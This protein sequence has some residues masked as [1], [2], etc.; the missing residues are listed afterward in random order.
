MAALRRAVRRPARVL[1]ALVLFAGGGGASLG[2]ERCGGVRVTAAV[3]L[4][5]TAAA[6]HAANLP[7]HTVLRVDLSDI[8]SAVKALVR[9]GPWDVC[10]LSAP[11]TDFSAAGRRVEGA[12]AELTLHGLE[13]AERLGIPTL[14]FENV[15]EVRGSATWEKA[16]VLMRRGG[17]HVQEAV[18]DAQ[19]FGVPQRRERHFAL[20]V[21]MAEP[22]TLA[23]F[24]EQLDAW[25]AESCKVSMADVL[26][27]VGDFVFIPTRANKGCGAAVR[28]TRAVEGAHGAQWSGVAPTLTTACT[29][30]PRAEAYTPRAQDAA[31]LERATRLS[32]AQVG[33][34][35]GFPAT[36][37]WPSRTKAGVM[38]GNAVAPPVMTAVMEAA[39]ATGQVRARE[40]V[41]A[42]DAWEACAEWATARAAAPAGVGGDVQEFEAD[43]WE[44]AAE[45]LRTELAE[46]RGRRRRPKSSNPE[47]DWALAVPR[48]AQDPAMARWRAGCEKRGVETL[49]AAEE[50]EVGLGRRDARIEDEPPLL[51]PDHPAWKRAEDRIRTGRALC[52]LSVPITG[53]PNARWATWERSGASAAQTTE[54]R[55]GARFEFTDKVPPIPCGGALEDANLP[56]TRDAVFALW[57]F[58]V[59]IEFLVLGVVVERLW[60]SYAISPL[61]CIGKSDFDAVTNPNRVRLLLDQRKLNE[62]VLAPPFAM[63]TLHR[64]RGLF[65]PGDVALCYDLSS[66]YFHA[67]VDPEFTKFL[68]CT[69]GGRVF[70]F[71]CAPMGTRSS[72]HIWQTTAWIIARKWRKMALRFVWYCD[73]ILILCR[74][75][76]AATIARFVEQE[77]ADHGLLVNYEKSIRAPVK[78]CTALGIDIDLEG[79]TF[80]IPAVRVAKTL[81]DIDEVLQA[82]RRGQEVQVRTVARVVGR[83]MSM[84]VVLGDAARRMTRA[85]YV[86]IAELTGVPPD[87]TRRE[88]KVAWDRTARIDELAPDAVRELQF[89]ADELPDVGPVPIMQVEPLAEV[90]VGSDA[91]DSAW[92]GFFDDGTGRRKRAR[93]VFEG[94][95]VDESS[96]LREVRGA[97]RTLESFEAE[98]AQLRGRHVLLLTD[99]QSAC[100]ALEVGSK[101]P[102]VQ[103]V[104]AEIFRLCMRYGVTLHPRWLRR[105]H[106]PMQDA[107]DGSKHRGPC[108]DDA[109]GDSCDYS[110]AAS[111][112]DR[113]QAAWGVTYSV[114]AF[115]TNVNA[116]V[117]RFFSYLYCPGTAAVD[118]FSR[119]WGAEDDMWLHPP[120][121]LIG[122]V[123]RYLQTCGGRGTIVVP[124]DTNAVWW[125]LVCSSAPGTVAGARWRWRR[126]RGLLV[127]GGSRPLPKTRFD[128]LAVRLDFRDGR[129]GDDGH[130]SSLVPTLRWR[131]ILQAAAARASER[132]ARA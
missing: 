56:G 4:D 97:A 119:D 76:Q 108:D 11:C 61:N 62:R 60:R 39:I 87:C 54:L 118:A 128:L 13:I 121:S 52:G 89:W 59:I 31:P 129:G 44:R 88:L 110:L 51:G 131:R 91:S 120:Y 30:W 53:W 90:G 14:V 25:A 70:E 112:F 37:V 38:I 99:N 96:T 15:V 20:A 2:L 92:A 22:G 63:E 43:S 123:V 102:A 35:Q 77:F 26:P 98:L 5:A 126:R 69:L 71:R 46:A 55:W 8:G 107:D 68:G 124:L 65:R 73:D 67:A 42:T 86:F 72:P 66:A 9:H 111:E 57:L 79:M 7:A 47:P 78:Q 12:A 94:A 83:I 113:L 18:V 58:Q 100:R 109:V 23:R 29:G 75:E 41:T 115:A 45:W 84:H 49:T 95:E 125:P 105:S 132:D 106:A 33:Q 103:T 117:P 80:A 10:Q 16:R 17:Y 85:A 3:E 28:S 24:S 114:D 50:E 27:E 64:A 81:V 40:E 101:N 82:A 104:A 48:Q 122:R 34:L 74:P 6:V 127:A 130:R 19:H 32:P 1:R 116:L 36:W 21:R 93:D